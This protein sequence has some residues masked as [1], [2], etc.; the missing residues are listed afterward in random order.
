MQNSKNAD[1][2][3]VDN[4]L[5][6]IK[7]RIAAVLPIGKDP[8][9]Y[10]AITLEYLIRNPDLFKCTQH[11]LDDAIIN[12]AMLGLELGDP[13]DL[14]DIGAYKDNRNGTIR[15]NLMI[16]YR[17]HML[18]VYATGKVK[19]ID[20]RAVYESDIFEYHFGLKPMLKHQPSVLPKRGMLTHAYAIATLQD[21]SRAA[22]VINRY[23][24]DKA[25]ADSP[26][27][28]KPESL[29]NRRT[30]EMW[31]KT[32]IK[33]LVNRLPRSPAPKIERPGPGA[34]PGPGSAKSEEYA[35]L[36]NAVLFAP[37]IYRKA[38]NDLALDFPSDSGSIKA[39]LESM[40]NHYRT[41]AK[42][43][44]DSQPNTDDKNTDRQ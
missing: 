42:K 24:A 39:V 15:A 43:D 18:Q 14:A 7:G 36:V 1:I 16:E 9:I 28:A 26:N 32:A 34:G 17:G 12:A 38:L 41:E 2:N 4:Y 8:D 19:S 6:R 21:G 37:D 27:S 23:D 30:A 31:T 3:K 40:R 35:N 13:F 5:S 25:R 22:E 20:A 29:W 33:K 11:S 44:Q 10:I